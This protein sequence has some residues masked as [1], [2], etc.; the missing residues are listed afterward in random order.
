MTSGA[1]LY[2]QCQ[3]VK[4]PL[5]CRCE[6]IRTISA[7]LGTAV[8]MNSHLHI[9]STWLGREDY[10]GLLPSALRASLRLFKFVPDKFVEPVYS[11]RRF[12]SSRLSAVR[13][14][15]H[16]HIYSTWLGRED[17][18]GLLPSALRASLRLFKFVPDKFVE[19]VYSL[20]RFKSSRLSAVRMNSHLHIYSTWLGREDSNLRMSGS[21]PDALPLG[22]GPLYKTFSTSPLP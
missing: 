22:D 18:F 4:T 9:Y 13:M 6:F 7:D 14:N 3:Q 11:L 15:S 21:K 20:R 12:K 2:T 10:F 8:R 5:V 16:L 1:C 19:P 17:Y